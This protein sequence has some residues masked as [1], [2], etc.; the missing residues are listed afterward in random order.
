MAVEGTRLDT[1]TMKNELSQIIRQLRE[2]DRLKVDTNIVEGLLRNFMRLYD[3]V[4]TVEQQKRLVRILFEEITIDAS[5]QIETI[6]INL[7]EEVIRFFSGKGEDD[8]DGSFS[9]FSLLL[10]IA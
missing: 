5:R 4:L 8:P 6:R 3:E 10:S 9:P 2:H 7:N 1:E